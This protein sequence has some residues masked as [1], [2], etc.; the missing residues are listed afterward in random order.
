MSEILDFPERKQT[1]EIG[2]FLMAVDQQ[3]TE[4]EKKAL[5]ARAK[6]KPTPGRIALA[7]QELQFIFSG[8]NA[9]EADQLYRQGLH[10][11]VAQA[12]TPAAQF[13]AHVETLTE[14]ANRAYDHPPEES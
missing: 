9:E 11:V 7:R 5:L 14:L 4:A 8:G 1:T 12:N 3:Q 10:D 2:R 6:E 13:Y